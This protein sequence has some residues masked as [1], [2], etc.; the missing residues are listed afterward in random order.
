MLRR[1]W[2]WAVVALG[3]AVLVSLPALVEAL[4]AADRDVSAGELRE[5]VLASDDVAFSGYAISTGGLTLPVSD[6]LT[7]VADLLSDQTS[8]RAWYRGADDWR[9]DVVT[10]T[11]ET[12]THRDATGT[13]TWDYADQAASR[14]TLPP[15][16]LPT[17]PDLLPSALGRRLLSEA[18][19]DE[20][21]RIAPARVAGVDAPGLRYTPADTA[22]SVS[23]VDVWVDP[24]TGLPLRVVVRGGDTTTPALDTRFLDLSL[25]TPDASTTDFRPPP[26]ADIRSDQDLTDVDLG[27]QERADLPATLAD[28]GRRGFD[29]VPEQIGVYGSGITVLAVSALPGRAAAALRDQLAATPGAVTDDLGVRIAAGPLALMVAGTSTRDGGT[30]TYLLAGTVTLDALATAARQ[31]QEAA[32]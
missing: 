30:G 6:A 24:G 26:G 25:A 28:L 3:L 16:A 4:P 22:A 9:V 10:A 23:A 17:A 8:L 5:R 20:L 32:S 7:G 1:R 27:R 12:G 19:D 15:L 31:I 14:G 13:W 21:S 2:R 11:G 29:G 18:T